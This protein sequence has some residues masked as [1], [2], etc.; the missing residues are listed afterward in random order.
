MGVRASASRVIVTMDRKVVD[1]LD[2]ESG[3]RERERSW[4][5]EKALLRWQRSL[6]CAKERRRLR[7]SRS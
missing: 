5:V 7:R 4:L 3:K 2:E 1:W 6:E